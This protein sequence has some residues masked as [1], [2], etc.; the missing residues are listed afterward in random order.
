MKTSILNA[1]TQPQL[2]TYLAVRQYEQLYWPNFFPVKSVATLDA[3]TLIG[4]SGNRVVANIISY[5]AKTPELSRK[6]LS[7]KYFEIPKVAAAIRK[8]ERE[9]LEHQILKSTIGMNAVIENYFADLDFCFDSVMGKMEW[10]ALQ[11]LSA[12][13]VTLSTTNNPLGIISETAIDFGLPTANKEVA[14]VTWVTGGSTSKPITDL[15]AVREAARAAGTKLRYALMNQATFDYLIVCDEYTNAAKPMMG[16]DITSGILPVQTLEVVNRVLTALG[17]PQV[18]IIDQYVSIENAAGT[19]TSTNCWT[20]NHVTFLPDFN[21]G[22]FLAGPIAE[23]IEKPMDVLQSKRGP[24][25]LSVQKDFNPVSVLTKG[26]AN[27]FPSW[28]AIDQC[29]ILDTIHTTAGTWA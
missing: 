25:L 28:G 18:V 2:D 3:K 8:T 7:T 21:C 26:E 14:S 13:T 10:F 6:S 16:L 1:I 15:K 19:R 17:L 23:E 22:N 29:Y 4:A 11:A 27:V 12:G 9:I 20:S 5:D 24:V